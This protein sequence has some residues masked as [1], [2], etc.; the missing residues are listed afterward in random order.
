MAMKDSGGGIFIF[1]ETLLFFIY[2][3]KGLIVALLWGDVTT[4]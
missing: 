1:L 2:T 3:Q 4:L